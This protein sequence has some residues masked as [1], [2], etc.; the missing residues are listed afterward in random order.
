MQVN[1]FFALE[2]FVQGSDGKLRSI[3]EIG[4]GRS[5]EPPFGKEP[6]GRS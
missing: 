3:S 6:F 1:L 5:M 4:D 2:E